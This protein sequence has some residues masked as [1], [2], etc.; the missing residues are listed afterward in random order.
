MGSQPVS[1]DKVFGIADKPGAG[2]AQ[3]A[4]RPQQQQAVNPQQLAAAG[5][6][7]PQATL[8]GQ[9]FAAAGYVMQPGVNMQQQLAQQ[10]A[11]AAAGRPAMIALPGQP[12]GQFILNQALGQ[13]ANLAL[14]AQQIQ[15]MQQLQAQQ[16]MRPMGQA[17]VAQGVTMRAASPAVPQQP[18][19]AAP[20]QQ[21]ARPGLPMAVPTQFT[22]NLRMPSGDV[23][24]YHIPPEFFRAHPNEWQAWVSNPALQM[25]M[26]RRYNAWHTARTAGAQ[27]VRPP[28]AAQAP[29]AKRMK[30]EPADV[31][32]QQQHHMMPGMRTPSPGLPPHHPP[33]QQTAQPAMTAVQ[34]SAA[35]QAALQQRLAAQSGAAAAARM[36]FP[37]IT[38][39]ANDEDKLFLPKPR[40]QVLV[41]EA[42][43]QGAR[44]TSEAELALKTLAQDFVS[45]AV[46]FGVSM[47]K[48]RKAE[49]LEQG[50]LQLYFER[51]WNL[52]IPGFSDAE[53]RPY[54]RPAVSDVHKA[55]MAAVRRSAAE[56]SAAAAAAAA[57]VTPGT[58]AAAGAA[59]AAG[60]GAGTA[61]GPAA[62][63]GG[64]AAGGAGAGDARGPAVAATRPAAE[65]SNGKTA[66][67]A[68]S[69]PAANGGVASSPANAAGP[70]GSQGP[71]EADK[72]GA[73]GKAV[74]PGTAEEME[75][76]DMPDIG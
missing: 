19:A 72:A 27:G 4:P 34:A 7:R 49:V 12:G 73:V 14:Y 31:L 48:R 17:G 24:P 59:A 36:G 57:G 41:R 43:G 45:N 44:M 23:Q 35:A 10:A 2:A 25:D 20:Q 54:R 28:A 22:I 58:A 8:P 1:Y 65:P 51:T 61:P 74:G 67:A 30:Q 13:Q 71:S 53:V 50:D 33:Q 11:A 63:V 39:P 76:E 38:K 3:G 18:Q 68:A 66:A 40:L 75:E 15:A 32:R 64:A 26:W 52:Q 69:L 21:P 70:K 9:Q 5:A 42:C 56:A 55:R 62:A 46:A 16:A 47:A 6:A 29:A 37:P 60:G